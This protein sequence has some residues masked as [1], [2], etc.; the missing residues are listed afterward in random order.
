MAYSSTVYLAMAAVFVG[1]GANLLFLELIVKDFPGSGNIITFAQFLFI[2][3]EGFIFTTRFGTKKNVIPIKNYVVMVLFF[4]TTSVVNNYALNFKI[5]VPLHTIFRSGSLIANMALG[6]ILLQKTYTPSKY[7]GVFSISVGICLCTLMSAKTVGDEN[8]PKTEGFDSMSDFM[9]WVI[10]VCMLTF[11]LFMSARMGIFQET[12]YKKFGKHPIEALFYSHA[13]PL[14]A[15]LLFAS[16]IY[17]H[18][19]MYSATE[20]A[21]IGLGITLPR[22]WLYLL[23]NILTQFVCIRGVF[24]LTTECPSLV[25]TLVVTLRKFLSLV[26]SIFY[27]KNPFTAWHWLGTAMVFGGTLL[28]TG[29]PH[30]LWDALVGPPMSRGKKA[31]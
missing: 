15:F 21:A 11:A 4:F 14:P 25:V 12:L 26:L 30:Q 13:L 8:Q 22:M 9:L 3:V 10:G 6:I 2:A 29:V 5:S 1:C 27:F 7:L 20:P 28:F 23:G 16:D 19:V 18:C 24:V 31:E 17:N